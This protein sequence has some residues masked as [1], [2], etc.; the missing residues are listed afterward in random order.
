MSAWDNNRPEMAIGPGDA[1]A[2]ERDA[3][4][5][6]VSG[7]LANIAACYTDLANASHAAA[8]GSAGVRVAVSR[9][10]PVPVDVD[11]VD[12]T[13]PAN[14]ASVLVAGS[15]TD[16]EDLACQVG[17]VAVASEL[18]FW[19]C[20]WASRCAETPPAPN[21]AELCA[22]LDVRLE[23]AHDEFP[24]WDEMAAALDRVARALR[25]TLTPKRARSVPVSAP[26]PQTGCEGVMA[27][28]E[29]AS[30]EC[31]CGRVLSAVEYRDWAFIV[32]AKAAGDGWGITAR[33][34]QLTALT[35]DGKPRPLGTIHSWASR[36]RWT[37]AGQRPVRYD[38]QQVTRT[39]TLITQREAEEAKA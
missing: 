6:A 16:P 23:W 15:M 20:D 13:G 28:R 39:L 26:C 14:A 27:V 25:G 2:A 18:D 32:I 7:R 3:A 8:T 33:E 36:Y 31:E 30:V 19:A 29:D 9:T 17:H 4:I 35:R 21:V 5:Q 38:R 10:P 37:K 24:A 22:W 1:R 12:L 34:I 11:R